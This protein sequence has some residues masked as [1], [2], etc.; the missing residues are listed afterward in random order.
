MDSKSRDP[1]GICADAILWWDEVVTLVVGCVDGGFFLFE[2][3]VVI[4]S[5]IKDF[6]AVLALNELDI[7]LSGDNFDD[8][9][10]AQ[11]CHG[12]GDVDGR[13]LPVRT[14]LVNVKSLRFFVVIIGDDMEMLL[15]KRGCVALILD[16]H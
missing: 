7:V 11:G 12:W 2:R 16:V 13:I 10:F 15:D 4:F 14:V 3:H 9:M 5:G 1:V 8:G 6:S